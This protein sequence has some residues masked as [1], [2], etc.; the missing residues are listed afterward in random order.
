MEGSLAL[1]LVEDLVDQVSAVSRSSLGDIHL[2]E[3]EVAL[4]LGFLVLARLEAWELALLEHQEAL[5]LAGLEAPALL[6]DLE[7]PGSAW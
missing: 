3:W 6:A 2:A 4:E 1:G 7:H 5:D